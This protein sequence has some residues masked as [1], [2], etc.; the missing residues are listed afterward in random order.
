MPLS[1]A[2][3]LLTLG[4]TVHIIRTSNKINNQHKRLTGE[5]PL[6]ISLRNLQLLR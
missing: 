4:L 2:P 3:F 6:L 5:L 1:T